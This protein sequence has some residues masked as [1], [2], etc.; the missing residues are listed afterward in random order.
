MPTAGSRGSLTRYC[1]GYL[2]V[3]SQLL[4]AAM[5]GT[6]LFACFEMMLAEPTRHSHAR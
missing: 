2:V 1:T 3:V 6:T 4:A 5:A